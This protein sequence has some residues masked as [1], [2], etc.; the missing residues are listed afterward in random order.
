MIEAEEE[1]REKFLREESQGEA[2]ATQ[3]LRRFELN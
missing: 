2:L 3:L 1:V